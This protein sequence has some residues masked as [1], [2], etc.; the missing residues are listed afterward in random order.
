MY[1]SQTHSRT[2]E[3]IPIPLAENGLLHTAVFGAF[4][5]VA[6]TMPQVSCQKKTRM[7]KT[8]TLGVIGSSGYVFEI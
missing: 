5:V 8:S 6:S 3:M 2:Q 7:A 1:T 4:A